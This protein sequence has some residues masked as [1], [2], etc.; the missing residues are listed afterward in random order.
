MNTAQRNAYVS[1]AVT[2]L[3]SLLWVATLR[4]PALLP[5]GETLVVIVFFA[6]LL[7]IVLALLL[8]NPRVQKDERD[9]AIA[10]R[11]MSLAYFVLPFGTGALSFWLIP[12]TVLSVEQVGKFLLGT[13]LAAELTRYACQSWLYRE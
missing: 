9:V 12:F 4:E 13:F 8:K 6:V 10:T 3:A 5:F 11:S 1:L 7:Q 2:V